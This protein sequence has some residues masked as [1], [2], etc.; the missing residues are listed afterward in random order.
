MSTIEAIVTIDHFDCHLILPIYF[1]VSRPAKNLG[2]EGSIDRQ[3]WIV[4]DENIKI[5]SYLSN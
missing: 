1:R 4:A 3:F 5:I 2:K